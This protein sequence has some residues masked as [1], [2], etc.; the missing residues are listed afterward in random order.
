MTPVE[1]ALDLAAQ[2]CEAEA[3]RYD[4]RAAEA[5]DD[6]VAEALRAFAASH[7]HVAA[8]IRAIPHLAK[9]GPL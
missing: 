2:E 6:R 5:G 1:H 8:R 3:A 4:L 7:R 9:G